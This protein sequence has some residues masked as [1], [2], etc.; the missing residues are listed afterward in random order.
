M[1]SL[2]IAVSAA[3]IFVLIAAAAYGHL[4]DNVFRQA[5][6]L[7]VKPETYNIV[8]RDRTTFKIY[9]Q[10]NM[11][12]GIA[13]ISLRAASPA[14]DFIITPSRMSIPKDHRV[15]FEVTMIVKE[16]AK[17]GSYPI[18][19]R[20]V[21]GGREFKRFSLS[22]LSSGQKS[23]SL[24]QVK[25]SYEV[26]IVDGSLGD[27]C[28]KKAAVASN[29]SSSGGGKAAFQTVA[30]LAFDEESLHI[31]VRCADEIAANLTAGDRLDIFLAMSASRS[32]TF[33]IGI[34]ALGDVRYG[35]FLT[36]TRYIAWDS[37]GKCRTSRGPNYWSTELSIPLASMGIGA[38]GARQKWS[39]RIDRTK[40]SGTAEKSCWAADPSGYNSPA[41]FGEILIVPGPSD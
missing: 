3:V 14:F 19:F 20:L 25:Q 18:N 36:S 23:T 24:L 5:D 38:P 29:F 30:L 4:C 22:S 13:E 37:G 33:H 1:R 34:T 11:D 26:P 16:S 10:N 39:L 32:P 12:R 27:G 7:I 15:Y 31:G 28:W 6:R 41:G 40:A 8:V 2:F 21:G 17:S 9:L 35:K